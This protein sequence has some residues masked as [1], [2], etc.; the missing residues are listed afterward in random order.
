MMISTRPI[1]A[2]DACSIASECS[3]ANEC[4]LRSIADASALGGRSSHCQ[5]TGRS[6]GAA[7]ILTSTTYEGGSFVGA[8]S[9][10][11]LLL[12]Q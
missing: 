5:A 1:V 10:N 6:C 4:Q 2:L 11:V 7:S 12:A 9:R 8:S 3:G